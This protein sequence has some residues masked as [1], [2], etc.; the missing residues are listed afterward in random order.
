MKMKKMAA[1]LIGTVMVLGL[2]GC[3]SQNTQGSRSG[4][5]SA[6]TVQAAG[7]SAETQSTSVSEHPHTTEALH[8]ASTEAS[9]ETSTDNMAGP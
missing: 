9:S 7:G 6:S 4:Q 5:N 8:D 3:G 2:A 1:L